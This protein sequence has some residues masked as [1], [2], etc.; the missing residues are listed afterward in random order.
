MSSVLGVYNTHKMTQFH[1]SLFIHPLGQNYPVTN[2]TTLAHNLSMNH[3]AF[4]SPSVHNQ[5]VPVVQQAVYLILN[6]PKRPKYAKYSHSLNASEEP[7]SFSH[8][9]AVL[10]LIVGLSGLIY[11]SS[12]FLTS[13]TPS[14]SP[15]IFSMTIPLLSALPKCFGGEFE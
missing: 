5:D 12:V 4:R 7:S 13:T 1:T 15:M 10:Q 11:E 14:F 6:D 3:P 2:L 8:A 9:Q